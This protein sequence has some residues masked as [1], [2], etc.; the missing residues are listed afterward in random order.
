ME[1]L[2]CSRSDARQAFSSMCRDFG[3]RPRFSKI[4]T[5]RNL[6]Q[7]TRLDSLSNPTPRFD[8]DSV[9]GRGPATSRISIAPLGLRLAQGWEVTGSPG[10]QV[11]DL[12]P[13]GEPARAIRG[14]P[15]NDQN[16]V[17]SQLHGMSARF[18]NRMVDV[19]SGG[20]PANG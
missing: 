12:P 7:C 13:N 17:V 16:V 15:R 9:Y 10:L 3:G 5:Q 18:H 14:D 2:L 6:H 1:R 20:D 11:C 19:L 4:L 8:L